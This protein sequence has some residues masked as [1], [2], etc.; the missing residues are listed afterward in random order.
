MKVMRFR[1][2]EEFTFTGGH[3]GRQAE[4]AEGQQLE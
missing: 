2:E 4:H 1:K 3:K